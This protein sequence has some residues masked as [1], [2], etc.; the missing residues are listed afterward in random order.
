MPRVANPLTKVRKRLEPCCFGQANFKNLP[1]DKDKPSDPDKHLNMYRE[2][3]PIQREIVPKVDE[4]LDLAC[5]RLGLDRE[6]VHGF[7]KSDPSVNAFCHTSI[8]GN[9]V[10]GVNSGTVE[11][12]TMN[13]LAYVFGHE[14]G[15]YILPL[16]KLHV[17][18]KSGGAR[19]ASMEDAIV[20][21]KLEISMDRFGLVACQDLQV[22]CSAAIKLA[23]GLSGAEITSDAIAFTKE[24]VK[25]YVRDYTEYEDEAYSSHP[26]AYARIRSLYHFSQSEDYLALIGRKGGKPHDEVDA[27]VQKDLEATLDYFAGKLMSDAISRFSHFFA[28]LHVD[29]EGSKAELSRHIVS[30][31]PSLDA[32]KVVNLVGLIRKIPDERKEKETFSELDEIL[33]TAVNRCP[34]AMN[35]HLE[36]LLPK[37]GGTKIEALVDSFAKKFKEEF[38]ARGFR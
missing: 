32:E 25:G 35:A 26:A 10:V 24:A 6:S 5:D 16:P 13:E 1:K 14:L 11:R 19:P 18:M 8:R 20:H 38:G 37:L 7:V 29:Q 21:R 2:H 36:E 22:A 34:R 15:H 30:R 23:S 3:V 27:E 4:A 33:L 9:A 12:L 28:A 31:Q 17:F